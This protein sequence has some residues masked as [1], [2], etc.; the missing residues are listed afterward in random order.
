[1]NVVFFGLKRAY[2]A[3]LKTPRV[4]LARI[5]MTAARY[6][7]MKAVG[8][9]RRLLQKELRRILSVTGATLSKMLKLL[10]ARGL[11]TRRPGADRRT[12]VVELT[13]EGELTLVRADNIDAR[14]PNGNDS[15]DIYLE[16]PGADGAW[17]WNVT[18]LGGFD[19]QEEDIQRMVRDLGPAFGPYEPYDHC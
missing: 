12:R 19:E 13:F 17:Y 2:Y 15:T 16:L 4:P 14:D 8:R 6:D 18:M 3:T 7:L 1:M 9:Y 10:E 11:V 5:G